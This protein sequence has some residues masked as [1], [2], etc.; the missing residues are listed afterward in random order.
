MNVSL[1]LEGEH[2]LRQWVRIC[3]VHVNVCTLLHL[4]HLFVCNSISLSLSLSLF[5]SFL[6]S[7]CVFIVSGCL[8]QNLRVKSMAGLDKERLET[9][10]KKA[11]AVAVCGY[12]E[13]SDALA[14]IA[15]VHIG[16][17]KEGPA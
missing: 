9:T 16:S 17:S 15:V 5:L 12:I 13:G 11:K 8:T 2:T 14:E 1:Q 4:P 6:I 10:K 3:I 7:F